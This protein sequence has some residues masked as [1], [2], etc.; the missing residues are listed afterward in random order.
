MARFHPFA[1]SVEL[2]SRPEGSPLLECRAGDAIFQVFERTGP[3]LAQPGSAN[4]ILNPTTDLLEAG[5]DGCKRIEATG[6][7]KVKVE[8]VVLDREPMFVVVD[9][10]APLIVSVVGG[11]DDGVA[12]GDWVAFESHA[13]IH[14]F[15]LVSHRG[16]SPS[17]DRDDLV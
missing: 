14:A 8:G 5:C 1:A 9:A 4:M 12:A 17:G 2:F 3:Y 13:P 10:G 11:V 15:V 6:L 16:S 7:A